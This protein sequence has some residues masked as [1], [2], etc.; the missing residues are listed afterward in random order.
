MRGLEESTVDKHHPGGHAVLPTELEQLQHPYPSGYD[1][2]CR[3]IGNLTQ[4]ADQRE[5]LRLAPGEH[6]EFN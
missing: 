1:L 3:Y 4:T 5:G 6:E 2:V